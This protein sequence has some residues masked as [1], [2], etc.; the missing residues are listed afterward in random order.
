MWIVLCSLEHKIRIFIA[1][2]VNT[3]WLKGH[4][5]DSN[6]RV[7][8]AYNTLGMKENGYSLTLYKSLEVEE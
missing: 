7:P 4:S 6:N 5:G 2:T 8:D 3:V 1:A